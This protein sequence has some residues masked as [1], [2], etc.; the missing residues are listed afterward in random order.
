MV[1]GI[2]GGVR[3]R[4]I[5][6][7]VTPRGDEGILTLNSDRWVIEVYSTIMGSLQAI[8]WMLLIFF[9]FALI[10]YVIVRAFEARRDTEAAA[11]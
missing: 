7:Y 3:I 2:G 8:A 9:L 4:Q 6:R 5:E 1:V 11:S 10:A